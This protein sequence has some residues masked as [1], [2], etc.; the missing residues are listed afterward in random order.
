[1]SGVTPFQTVGPYFAVMLRSRAACTQITGPAA[2]PRIVIDGGVVDAE[3]SPIPDAFV[4]VWQ[5]D[6]SGRYRH[7]DDPRSSSADPA[8]CGYG[9]AHTRS[10]GGFTFDTVKPGPVPGPD[11]GS[12]APHVLV[13]VMARG[14]LTRF[15]TRMYFE[16]EPANASDPVL[17]LVPEARRKTLIARQTG[18]HAYRFEIA[19]QGPNE[20]VFFDL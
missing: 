3:G 11:G 9:W 12:Q 1:M 10:D 2:G 14:I 20:T 7:P 6:A 8:F 18:D 5:A 17:A 13:S 16:G 15:I 19:M 4:E